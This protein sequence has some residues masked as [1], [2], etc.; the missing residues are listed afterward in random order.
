MVEVSSP[1]GLIEICLTDEELSKLAKT[2]LNDWSISTMWDMDTKLVM[3]TPGLPGKGISIFYKEVGRYAPSPYLISRLGV[4]IFGITILGLFLNLFDAIGFMVIM[5]VF[6]VMCF[7]PV[8]YQ[9]VL[10]TLDDRGILLRGGDSERFLPFTEVVKVDKGLFRV[11]VTA[12]SGEIFYFPKA[13]YLLADFI[14]TF[15]KKGDERLETSAT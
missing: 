6:A 14:K 15:T 1:A 7:G 13:C 11:K 3:V 2:R 8:F 4:P 9:R 12:K 10:V 5:A